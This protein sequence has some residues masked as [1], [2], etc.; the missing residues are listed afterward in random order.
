MQL[1]EGVR[2]DGKVR[3]RI[4]SHVGVASNEAE[5]AR[6][7]ELG[8]FL[9]A[10]EAHERQPGLFPP[11]QVAEELIDAGRRATET[12]EAA[13]L[14]VDLGALREE[15]R[16]ITGIHEAYGCVYRELGLDRLLSLRHRASVRTL[17]HTVMAR[18][19][20]PQSKRESIRRLGR[21]FGVSL[22][23][24]K[25]YRMFGRVIAACGRWS[26]VFASASMI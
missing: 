9:K 10:R 25:V 24:E 16:I 17:F 2:V 7:K 11:E 12:V 20:N 26:A 18:I 1:V 6:L 14:P 23:L 4:V 22:S 5:L 3:Q 13:P 15:R 8:E 21:D 19:A